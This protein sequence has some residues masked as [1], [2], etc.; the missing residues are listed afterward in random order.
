MLEIFFPCV[1]KYSEQA[2]RA[3][4]YKKFW[5]QALHT[6]DS[7]NKAEERKS[8]EYQAVRAK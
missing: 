7:R 8:Q 6:K 3:D 4:V 5:K 1:L 2:V